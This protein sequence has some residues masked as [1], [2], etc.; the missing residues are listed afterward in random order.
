M[1]VDFGLY[2]VKDSF[3]SDFPNPE[4]KYNKR[5]RPNF[6]AIRDND[7]IFW[8]VPLS[9]QVDTYRGK[10]KKSEERYGE[11]NCVYY[12]I[13]RVAGGERAFLITKM[14]PVTEE[15]IERAYSINGKPYISKTK[16]L[17][18]EIRAKVIKYQALVK[19]GAILDERKIFEV[20]DKLLKT[21]GN[22]TYKV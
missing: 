8:M 15:Y 21:K 9:S 12:H 1:I 17:N 6:L 3:F 16:N 7:S 11:G 20:K 22:F 2:V 5:G 19:A 14:F 13:G 18:E 10:I 4:W